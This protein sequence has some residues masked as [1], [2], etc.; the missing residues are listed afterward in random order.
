MDPLVY[1]S[2]FLDI[3]EMIFQHFNGKDLI[4]ISEVNPNYYNFIASSK[5]LMNKI[6]IVFKDDRELFEEDYDLLKNSSRFYQNI[7]V[8]R[9]S[10]KRRLGEVENTKFIT[11]LEFKFFFEKNF[12]WKEIGFIETS[13]ENELDLWELLSTVQP[14]VEKLTLDDVA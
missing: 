9:D 5:V 12:S 14:T 10:K 1:F 7:E 2:R 8:R 3:P 6:K 4:K 13:F 11:K